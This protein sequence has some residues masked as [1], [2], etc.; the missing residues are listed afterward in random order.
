MTLPRDIVMKITETQFLPS[1]DSRPSAAPT[2]AQ[3][4]NERTHET[5]LN[6]RRDS[7]LHFPD[8]ESPYEEA[9]S[10]R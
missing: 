5:P 4:Q 3:I 1:A 6:P 9:V 7:P 10:G 8:E 2:P